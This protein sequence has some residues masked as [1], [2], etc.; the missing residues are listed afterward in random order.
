MSQIVISASR[1]TDIPAFY[2]PWF[3]DRI[4]KGYFEVV[5]PYNRRT[6]IVPATPAEVHT[7]V[8]WSKNFGPFITGRYGEKLID[9]GY[10]LFF[11]YTL[12]SE[13]PLLEPNLPPLQTRMSQLG[14]YE[15]AFW[16]AYNQLAVRSHLFLPGGC[17]VA[18]MITCMTL[19]AWL[20]RPHGAVSVAASPALET[21]TARSADARASCRVLLLGTHR[22]KPKRRR[23]CE[24]K[25][26][27]PPSKLIYRFAVKANCWRTCRARQQ[28]RAVLAFP[29][30]C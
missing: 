29:M 5:N 7:I 6:S 16:A 21:T 11:N 1:R 26:C 12:N 4:D 28:L 30:I 23:F 9:A 15:R 18:G 8:F 24:W 27:W 14:D 13:S 19:R 20:H 25:S 22:W 2:M 10:H 17:S 3:M